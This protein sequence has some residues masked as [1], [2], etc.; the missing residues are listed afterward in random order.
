MN[1]QLISANDTFRAHICL[2]NYEITH[3]PEYFIAFKKDTFRLEMDYSNCGIFKSKGE[4]IGKKQY[5]GFVDYY[6]IK[7]KKIRENFTIKYE[8]K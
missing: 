6:D 1:K 5:Q 7:G 2:G 3:L 8:I 4:K